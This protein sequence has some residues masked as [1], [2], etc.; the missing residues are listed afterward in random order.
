VSPFFL[1]EGQKAGLD[2]SAPELAF[3]PFQKKPG[4]SKSFGGVTAFTSSQ[5]KNLKTPNSPQ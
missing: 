3:T 5:R 1:G 2:D 4:R